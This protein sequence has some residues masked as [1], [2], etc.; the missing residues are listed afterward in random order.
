MYYERADMCLL[1]LDS[2]RD[3]KLVSFYKLIEK[4]DL[5]PVYSCDVVT[6][7][8]SVSTR[9]ALL[10]KEM[11]VPTR[12]VRNFENGC[13]FEF[14]LAPDNSVT[15]SDVLGAAK[16]CG[17]TLYK[18]DSRPSAHSEG[19]FTYDVIVN[20]CNACELDAFVLFMTLAVPQYEPL[21]IYPHIR[22]GE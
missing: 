7:D 21:G 11:S 8:G 17:M 4:Y 20:V 1:P 22:V 19:T 14:S 10:Q 12:E 3:S 18:V 2:S 15:L 6:P 9:Y 13:L 5:S 16:S